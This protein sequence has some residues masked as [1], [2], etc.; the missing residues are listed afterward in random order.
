[1]QQF[2]GGRISSLSDVIGANI[3]QNLRNGEYC[4]IMCEKCYPASRQI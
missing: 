1:M 4:R 3:S 2:E